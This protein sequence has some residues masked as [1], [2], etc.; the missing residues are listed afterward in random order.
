M[1]CSTDGSPKGCAS[2]SICGGIFRD[3]DVNYLGSFAINL[4]VT[5]A[6]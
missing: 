4:H 3:K 1:K 2:P 6:S 5:T